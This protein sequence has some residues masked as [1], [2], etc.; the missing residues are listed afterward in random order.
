MSAAVCLL[1]VIICLI[2]AAVGSSRGEQ[3]FPA[4]TD[5]GRCYTYYF[6]DS[7]I[8]RVKFDTIKAEIN[9]IGNS[10]H[11]CIEVINF[12]ENLSTFSNSNAMVTFKENP[13]VSSAL[14]FWENGFNFK[15]LRYIFRS[16]GS[17]NGGIINVYL[18]QDVKV[19]AFDISTASGKVNISSLSDLADY[20]ITIGNGSV[21][22]KDVTS[23]SVISVA[24]T[25]TG[26][27]ALS[28]ENVNAETFSL[29]AQTA[30][31]KCNGVKARSC[32]INVRTG[33]A[34]VNYSPSEGDLFTV[35]VNTM[36]KLSVD[37]DTEQINIYKYVPE[38]FENGEIP[39]GTPYIK[40]SGDDLSVTL[41]TPRSDKAAE[42]SEH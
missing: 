24:A 2:G 18:A 39:E 6:G 20:N 9:I 1:G 29:A 21:T 12:D 28:F 30:D 14:K 8:G 34:L 37:G 42:S 10:D 33:S 35:D 31:L 26:K 16:G 5:Y 23:A 40:I 36:G 11:S 3:I 13:D 32:D 22:V 17:E 27:S 15:G 38:D 4:N 19:K 41:D 25:E 7:D